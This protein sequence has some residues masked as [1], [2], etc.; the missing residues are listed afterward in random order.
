VISIDGSPI[1]YV[2]DAT[3]VK[4]RK[5]VYNGATTDYAGNF[6]YE[7]GDL[8]FFSHAEGYTKHD[9]GKFFN[10]YQYK[11]HLG[12]V[13]LSYTDADNDGSIDA[14]TEIVEESNYYPFGLKHKGYNNVV[15]SNGNSVAQKWG[16]QEQELVDDLGLNVH[17]WKYRVSDPAIGR[18]WQIDPLAED[19]VHNG[20]YNF[21]ENRLIDARELEGLEAAMIKKKYENNVSKRASNIKEVEKPK[22]EGTEVT[23]TS[24]KG[25]IGNGTVGGYPGQAI[26]ELISRGV[27]WLASKAIGSN[28]SRQTADN[29]QMTADFAVV[30]LSKGKNADAAIDVAENLVKKEG[31]N[32]VYRALAEG[33]DI[34]KGLTARAPNVGNSPLSH[35]A[36][37]RQSQWISTTKSYK[38]ALEKYAKG[39]PSK[40]IRI[41]LEKVASKKVDL[42]GGIPKGGRFSY[43]A[44]KDAEV[45]IKNKIPK[46]AISL[47]DL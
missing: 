34:T 33:E 15:S 32:I 9:A 40:V 37:K 42:S 13:R 38:I 4:L 26:D 27:Q 17:E 25:R 46:K 39:D 43:Y 35:V 8:Q 21:S 3:G 5:T 10:I 44:K 14:A 16:F 24:I 41:N 12:N 28:V 45:L 19:Y 29:I 30:L 7:N 2:Y 22:A 6:I 11:D 31:D 18:F 47:N 36:G 1:T 20:A 23:L